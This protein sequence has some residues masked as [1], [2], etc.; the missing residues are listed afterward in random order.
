MLADESAYFLAQP[1][2]CGPVNGRGYI[3]T[4]PGY[5]F[6]DS[7][8]DTFFGEFKIWLKQPIGKAFVICF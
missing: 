6:Y 1:Q 8:L 4:A 3:T 2:N 5:A 7:R